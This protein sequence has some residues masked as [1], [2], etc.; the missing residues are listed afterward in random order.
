[1]SFIFRLVVRLKT[2]AQMYTNNIAPVK[3]NE[4]RIRHYRTYVGAQ[5]L[6]YFGIIRDG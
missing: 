2:T 6:R 3:L 1:M 5:R 4:A